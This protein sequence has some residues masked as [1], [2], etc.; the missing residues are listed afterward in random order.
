MLDAPVRLFAWPRRLPLVALG[1]ALLAPGAGAIRAAEEPAAGVPRLEVARSRIF[2]PNVSQGTPV[3][4]S[5]SLRNTGD[6]LLR[7]LSAKPG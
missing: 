4:A 1:L 6:G 2:V 3:E 5:F 7:V